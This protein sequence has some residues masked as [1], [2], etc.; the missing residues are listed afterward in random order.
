ML[1][2]FCGF[3]VGRLAFWIWS[4]FSALL[5]SGSAGIIYNNTEN[6]VVVTTAPVAPAT[7]PTLSYIAYFTSKEVGDDINLAG[8]DRVVRRFDFMTY[9]NT[10]VKPNAQWKLRF[11]KNNGPLQIPD[12]ASSQ[13]PGTL[14][15]ESD[16]MPLRFTSEGRFVTNIVEVPNITVPDRFTWTV[17]FINVDQNAGTA[18]QAGLVV[19]DP[20]T[21]GAVLKGVLRDTIGSYTDYWLKIDAEDPESWELN[22]FNQ[23]DQL[24][25]VGN[26]YALVSTEK[27]VVPIAN[28]APSF[29][30]AN[31]TVNELSLLTFNLS[32]TDSDLPAQ[33]L[34][35]SL[36]SGPAGM[37]VSVGGAVNWTP[38]EVQGPYTLSPVV[39]RVSDGVASVDT[40]FFV[41]V[42]EV[43]TA[44]IL[45]AVASKMVNELSLLT[46]NLS[47]T[48]SDRPAQTLTY[49]LVSGPAGMT[50]SGVGAVNW[51]PTGAQGG[52]VSPV[53]V[54][55]SDGSTGVNTSFTVTVNQGVNTAPI[56]AAVANKTVNELSL[57]TFNLSATDS[58]LPAQTLTYS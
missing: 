34:T 9:A 3:R 5:L 36:V 20:P 37:T 57:L 8:T 19:A 12:S 53:V 21:V 54:R 43:N 33:T 27:P 14:L 17:Q 4:L 52:S 41:T 7:E 39:V 28:T 47:A 29:A 24:A 26:F 42:S 6:L 49:S 56:L 2:N 51:T 40:S 30:V 11:Y 23:D 18:D 38:T 15:W 55:V 22:I 13:M 16:T 48:D 25:R 44:P 50:V 58:D 1:V 35:Y 31:K 10:G 45:A 46:F 32:A